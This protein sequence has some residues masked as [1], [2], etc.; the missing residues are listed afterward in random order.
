MGNTAMASQARQI[1]FYRC[2]VEIPGFTGLTG[3][4]FG[5]LQVT[6]KAKQCFRSGMWIVTG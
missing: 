2:L 1:V 3:E 5:I 6:I 4:G